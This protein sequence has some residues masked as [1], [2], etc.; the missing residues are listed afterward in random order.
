MSLTSAP[1]LGRGLVTGLLADGV[2]LALVLGHAGVD[3]FDDVGANRGRENLGEDLGGTGSL[4]I[5]ADDG[6]GRSG[7]HCFRDGRKGLQTR[8]TTLARRSEANFLLMEKI[9]RW[10]G[11][12][13]A[14]RIQNRG[15]TYLRGWLLG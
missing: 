13:E 3:V 1:R 10:E 9:K 2:R 4:A 8:Q 12:S 5:G 6:D 11:F 14:P 15:N 7:G